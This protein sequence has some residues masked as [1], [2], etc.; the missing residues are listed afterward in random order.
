LSYSENERIRIGASVRALRAVRQITQ[1]E[2][3]YAVGRSIVTIQALEHAR[4]PQ[5]RHTVAAVAD[6]F[7]TTPDALAGLEPLELGKTPDAVVIP[8]PVLD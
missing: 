2:L 3:A 7:H 6:Y 5:S 4:H 1:A 8:I